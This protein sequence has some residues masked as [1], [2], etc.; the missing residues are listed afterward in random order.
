VP[1]LSVHA[2]PDTPIQIDA[3]TMQLKPGGA[4]P[5]SWAAP[6]AKTPQCGSPMV[7]MK[8]LMYSVPPCC[9]PVPESAWVPILTT[10]T[11]SSPPW[12]SKS[13]DLFLSRSGCPTQLI[14]RA[15]AKQPYE[16]KSIFRAK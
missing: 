6:L 12:N 3:I 9:Q 1:I 16:S 5:A 7:T 15:Q 10:T 14:E 13:V 8:T 2:H 11:L 4:P